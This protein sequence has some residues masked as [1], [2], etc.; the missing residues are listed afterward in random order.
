MQTLR[1]SLL[2]FT[3][4]IMS[5]FM[6]QLHADNPLD[7]PPPPPGGGHGGGGNPQGAPIDSGTGILMLL[8]VSYGTQKII[9]NWKAEKQ[10]E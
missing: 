3:F 5:M 4:F 9:K 6:I 10:T 2:T 8:G 7:S 1:K